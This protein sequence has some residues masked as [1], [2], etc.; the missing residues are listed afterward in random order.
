MCAVYVAVHV[1]VCVAGY[2]VYVTGKTDTNTV[3]CVFVSL[4]RFALL[5]P[6]KLHGDGLR[7]STDTVP[8]MEILLTLSHPRKLHGDCPSHGDFMLSHP[9]RRSRSLHGDC[10]IHRDLTDTVPSMGTSRRLSHP[11]K[12]DGHCPIHGDGLGVSTETVPSTET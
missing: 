10:P 1:A 11:R 6:R 2:S 12:L 9:R 3:S 7:V 8:S 5:H 4:V